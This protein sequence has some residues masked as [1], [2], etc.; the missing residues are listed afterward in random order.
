MAK[1]KITPKQAVRL[2][3]NALKSGKYGWGTN[4]LH[5]AEDKYCCLG[6]LCE[7]AKEKGIIKRYSSQNGGLPEKVQAWVGLSTNGGDFNKNNS[8]IQ[9]NDLAP[10]NPFKPI[11]KLLEK[12][13]KGLFKA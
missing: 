5:P 11:A 12:R 9:V 7:I 10:R 1:L 3:I 6:V 13:P 8:L 2:W 4:K